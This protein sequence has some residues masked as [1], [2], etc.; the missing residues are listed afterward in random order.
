MAIYR[1]GAYPTGVAIRS[2]L[3]ESE[4]RERG[5]RI[6]EI[7]AACLTMGLA[8]A[9]IAVAQEARGPVVDP[10]LTLQRPWGVAGFS[11]SILFW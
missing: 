3:V 6:P 11:L 4:M 7:V 10:V 8:A 2:G 1:Y 9:G 5:L